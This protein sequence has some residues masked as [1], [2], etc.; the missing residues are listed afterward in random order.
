MALGVRGGWIEEKS[1]GLTVFL[2]CFEGYLEIGC[3]DGR[4]PRMLAFAL[5]RVRPHPP[6]PACW[7][8]QLGGL[9]PLPQLM[10]C[11]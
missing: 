5:G 6:P 1:G 11:A 4:P 9:D 3:L 10:Q 7:R 8:I 2:R